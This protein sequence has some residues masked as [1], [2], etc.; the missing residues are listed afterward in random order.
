[1]EV[2][3][4]YAR[5]LGCMESSTKQCEELASADSTVLWPQLCPSAFVL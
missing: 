2:A 5:T 4:G 1:M 3:A